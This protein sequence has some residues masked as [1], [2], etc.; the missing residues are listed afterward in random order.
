M[1]TALTIKTIRPSGVPK[2]FLQRIDRDGYKVRKMDITP[3]SRKRLARIV[4]QARRGMWYLYRSN[5]YY[6]IG[7]K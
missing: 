2:A 7:K 3:A 5:N 1:T 6:V 4:N